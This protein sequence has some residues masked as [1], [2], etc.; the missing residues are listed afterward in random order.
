[1]TESKI[2]PVFLY[3][4][5]NWCSI[6]YR[7]F[8]ERETVGVGLTFR[9]I[10]DDALPLCTFRS[11]GLVCREISQGCFFISLFPVISCACI[12]YQGH[13]HAVS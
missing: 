5:W 10:D 12:P 3:N 6:L 7:I 13:T 8:W 4:C 9:Y 11:F 2:L 1:M